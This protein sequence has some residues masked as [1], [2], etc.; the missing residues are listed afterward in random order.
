VNPKPEITVVA[1]Q[2]WNGA[3]SVSTPNVN[4]TPICA[5]NQ[6]TAIGPWTYRNYSVSS[7]TVLAATQTSTYAWTVLTETAGDILDRTGM[8]TIAPTIAWGIYPAAVAAPN[9]TTE[10]LQVIATTSTGCAD[11]ATYNV[12]VNPTLGDAVLT[13]NLGTEACVYNNWTP[14]RSVFTLGRTATGI[15]GYPAG[16]TFNWAV[17]HPREAT[18]PPSYAI[19][20]VGNS[21][22]LQVEWLQPSTQTGTASDSA[23]VTVTATLPAAWGGCAT[24]RTYNVFVHTTP[25]PAFLSGPTAVCPNSTHTYAAVQNTNNTYAWEVVGGTIA[26]G[27]G[28]GTATNPS[29][30]NTGAGNSISVTFGAA[31]TPAQV[32]LIEIN[33]AGCQSQI[34]RT[35][36]ITAPPTPFIRGPIISCL[37]ATE[38]YDVEQ[39]FLSSYAWSMSPANAGIPVAGWNTSNE[40]QIQWNIVGTHTL[41]VVETNDLG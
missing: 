39:N 22:T 35:V 19:F 16:T 33:E 2:S 18:N 14:A 15:T 25:T 36:T 28:A 40:I 27:A 23:T 24:T 3:T 6:Y 1:G 12:T 31:N 10:T 5:Q 38:S 4:Q 29:T 32:R 20:G 9:I 11:T 8:N 21:N 41:T 13:H 17:T 26:G 34:V 37:G 7:N 30:L